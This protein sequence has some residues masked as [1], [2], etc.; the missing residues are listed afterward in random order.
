MLL[1]ISAFSRSHTTTTMSSPTS[2][3]STIKQIWWTR[4]RL[5][6]SHN[7]TAPS[8]TW[9]LQCKVCSSSITAS[10]PLRTCCLRTRRRQAPSIRLPCTCRRHAARRICFARRVRSLTLLIRHRPLAAFLII[11]RATIIFIGSFRPSEYLYN[12]IFEEFFL[13]F[14][15]ALLTFNYILRMKYKVNFFLNL[16]SRFQIL[17]W[18]IAELVLDIYKSTLGIFECLSVFVWLLLLLFYYRLFLIII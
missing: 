13:F 7:S 3:I 12:Y 16:D 10:R 2:I 11:T 8:T 6:C 1:C 17:F 5:Q 15:S 14:L 9:T 4:T 18:Y